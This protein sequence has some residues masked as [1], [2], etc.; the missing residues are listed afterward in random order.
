MTDSSVGSWPYGA[1]SPGPSAFMVATAAVNAADR[2]SLRSPDGTLRHHRSRPATRFSACGRAAP[3]PSAR[4]IL[5]QALERAAVPRARER[6]RRR[7]RA[8]TDRPELRLLAFPHDLLRA[9]SC[10]FSMSY[11]AHPGRGPQRHRMSPRRFAVIVSGR[12]EP[13]QRRHCPW[14]GFA[15]VRPSPAARD[16]ETAARPRPSVV[17][18]RRVRPSPSYRREQSRC[19]R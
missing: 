1:P 10:S 6:R 5:R 18:A 13:L 11:R 3:N 17:T 16:D 12:Y 8:N 4:P 14:L 15:R 2:G 9:A 7:A 19:L